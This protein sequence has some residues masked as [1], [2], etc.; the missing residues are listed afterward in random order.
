ME[1]HATNIAEAVHYIVKGRP[2]GDERPKG[3]TTSF[4]TVTLPN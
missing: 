3:D 4:A 2:L 1:D